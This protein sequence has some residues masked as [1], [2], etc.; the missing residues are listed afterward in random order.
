M[1]ERS[2]SVSNESQKR[3]QW[4]CKN[5]VAC[6]FFLQICAL[7]GEKLQ[8]SAILVVRK[9][10]E[11]EAVPVGLRQ[12]SCTLF[13]AIVHKFCALSGEKWQIPGMLVVRKQWESEAVSVGLRQ[14]SCLLQ[15][16]SQICAFLG[17]KWQI[18]GVLIVRKQWESEAVPVCLRQ[19][20]CTLWCHLW[21]VVQ[22]APP[23]WKYFP[24]FLSWPGWRWLFF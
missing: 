8:I 7:L 15:F 13:A 22:W 2:C 10:W 16:L 18:S 6:K 17:E 11:S 3:F 23:S 5:P 9:Q 24:D 20:N 12:A 19:A 1:Y 21:L 14:A 4:A